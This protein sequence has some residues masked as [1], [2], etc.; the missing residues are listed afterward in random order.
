MAFSKNF[1]LKLRVDPAKDNRYSQSISEL[2]GAGRR[3]EEFLK[4]RRK[5]QK[6]EDG[7]EIFSKH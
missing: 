5:R 7:G 1:P 6:E 2:F 4:Q 3:T